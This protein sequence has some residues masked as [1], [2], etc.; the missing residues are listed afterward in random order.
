MS[1][2]D[3]LIEEIKQKVDNEY[4]KAKED[5][6]KVSKLYSYALNLL[7]R[8]KYAD[9]DCFKYIPERFKDINNTITELDLHYH[10][11][12]FIVF[13]C[14]N[15]NI[16][17]RDISIKT[18]MITNILGCINTLNYNIRDFKSTVNSCESKI[19]WNM[20]KDK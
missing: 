1:V 4:K 15:M 5:Y 2:E 3:K 8:T 6:K 19:I 12:C 17:M 16:N 9:K 13:K 11:I 7:H 14:K 18:T 20:L 10:S